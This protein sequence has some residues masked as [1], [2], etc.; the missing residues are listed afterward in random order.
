M[1]ESPRHDAPRHPVD[2]DAAST[3]IAETRLVRDAA[4]RLFD[5]LADASAAKAPASD[6]AA[7]C[8]RLGLDEAAVR[9]RA[10]SRS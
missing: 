9:E 6:L 4:F 1:P 3:V 7:V 8:A 5:A 10:T 2:R